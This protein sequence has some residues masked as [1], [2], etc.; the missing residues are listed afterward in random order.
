MLYALLALSAL[1][2]APVTQ[3]PPAAAVA[4]ALAGGP[5]KKAVA[6]TAKVAIALSGGPR[7]REVLP[8]PSLAWE[9]DYAAGFARAK[10]EGRAVVLVAACEACPECARL[11]RDVFGDAGV[12]AAVGGAVLIRIRPDSPAGKYLSAA[13]V[14]PTVY[15]FPSP[16]S[17][18]EP[19]YGV[20][21]AAE[22]VRRLKGVQ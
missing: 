22:V 7:K 9:R 12:R 8:Q 19:L 4:S 17:P 10:A 6:R 2:P 21:A 14:G 3:T 16:D 18:A 1:T 13:A 11:D 5:H 20:P 15:V